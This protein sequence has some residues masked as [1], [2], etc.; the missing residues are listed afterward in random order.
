MKV[1][2]NASPLIFLS[3]L[4]ELNLLAQCFDE[5][6]IPLAVRAEIGDLDLPNFVQITPIS[7][8]G[9]H[10][11]AGALG[12]LHAGELEAIQ[13]AEE[14]NAD[15]VLLDDFRARQNAKRK[16]LGIIGTIGILQ[17]AYARTLLERDHF[18]AHID[19]LVEQH[20]MWLSAAIIKQLKG[21]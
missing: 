1:V 20:G 16:E 11:V 14:T 18:R 19:A 2:S 10:Y 4:G 12:V 13:L 8:F 15:F 21:Y 6:H 7:E 5:V 17:L 3:K 9:K